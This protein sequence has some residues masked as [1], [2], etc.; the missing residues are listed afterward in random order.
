LSAF[1]V[2][3]LARRIGRDLVELAELDLLE[4]VRF[5]VDHRPDVGRRRH[6]VVRALRLGVADELE[7]RIRRDRRGA[8]VGDVVGDVDHVAAAM[9]REN[10]VD[11][12]AVGRDR[13]QLQ[14]QRIG[15][16]CELARAR[17]RLIERAMV[18]HAFAQQ[19]R[20]RDKRALRRA[21]QHGI[22]LRFVGRVAMS[23][24][25]Q[26]RDHTARGVDLGTVKIRR[27]RDRLSRARG[28]GRDGRRR[29]ARR[30]GSTGSR[31]CRYGGHIRGAARRSSGLRG[32]CDGRRHLRT[33]LLL[34]G[35]PQ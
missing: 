30:A 26:L 19:P 1:F 15:A 21:Q 3:E 10:L 33:L 14:L 16:W 29:R 32:R 13:V 4:L 11:F 17:V 35:L 8:C 12:V 7:V 23:E 28:G 18:G 24:Q 27:D 5:V 34:P 2:I 22:G 6:R 31:R 20:L 9:E 25:Q